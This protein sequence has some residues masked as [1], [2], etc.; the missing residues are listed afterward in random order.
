M[1]PLFGRSCKRGIAVSFKKIVEL[2][3]Q[4]AGAIADEIGVALDPGTRQ[5]SSRRQQ[6]DIGAYEAFLRGQREYFT[7]FTEESTQKAIALFQQSLRLDP[8][9]APAYSGL[10]N[11]YYLMSN[12]YY[13][14]KEMMPKAKAAA[15]NA[16]E[17]DDSL[18]GAHATM[19][20]VAALFDFDRDAAER[21]F[22]RALSLRPS[23]G[24]AGLWYAI[25]LNAMGRFNEAF[26]ELEQARK[27]D[28]V[29]VSINTYIAYA[30][31]FARRYDQM[32]ELL[33][34][35]AE[36]NPDY[37]QTHAFLTLAYEQ[38]HEWP[39]SNR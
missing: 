37:H 39:K 17:L 5:G 8:R 29:S 38:R 22:K 21:G 3:D 4:V 34:P 32:L 13:P 18:G 14:P 16:L 33:L 2:Q 20:L 7:A 10:A 36:R 31:Y 1:S 19:A 27:I 23:D 6:V 26:S 35:I 30:L 15:R 11:C 12:I 28:P 9:Y 25:H 24:L